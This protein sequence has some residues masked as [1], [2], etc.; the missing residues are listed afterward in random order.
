MLQASIRCLSKNGIFLEIG[1]FDLEND[2]KIGL[3]HFLKQIIV[4]SVMA[5]KMFN[6][7]KKDIENICHIIERDIETGIIQPLPSTVFNVNEL[8]KAFRFLSTGK[9]VGK[10]LIKIRDQ[11]NSIESVP[12]T[13]MPRIL[14]DYNFTYIILGGL[15]GFGLELVDWLILRGARKIVLSSSRGITN[16]YQEFRI[17]SFIN[18]KL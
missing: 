13:V 15:G 1:K 9:H 12:I 4:R 7:D 18:H 3:G 8:E 16:K 6:A 11:Y 5:D 2:T 14:C 10:V 17:R